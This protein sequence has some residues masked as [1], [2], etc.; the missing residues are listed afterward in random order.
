MQL[1]LCTISNGELPVERVLTVAA[2][3][4]YDGVEIWGKDHVGDSGE[5]TCGTIRQTARDLGLELPVYGSYLTVGTDGF[6]DAYE[7]ELRIADR[8]DADLIRVWPG[9]REYGDHDPA[10]FEAAVADLR[11]LAERASSMDLAVTVEKHEGRLSNTT[12]GAR[13][14]IGAV[15][16]PKCGLNWQPLFALSERDLLAEVDALAPLSNNVHLQ[17][18]AEPDSYDRTLLSEA[19]FDVGRILDRFEQVG[20]DGYVEVEFVTDECAYED[21]VQRDYEY[22]RSVT[23]AGD[24]D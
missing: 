15:D 10:E 1:G 6:D 16:H 11:T 22:L 5:D 14:L 3:V 20:F 18:P 24:R 19:Y 12:E 2:D 23:G 4:G 7:R 13:K 17:A 8:L 9:E 21:A